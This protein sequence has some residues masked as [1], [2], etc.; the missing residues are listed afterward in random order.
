MSDHSISKATLG[1]LPEYLRLLKLIEKEHK[2]ISATVIAKY[3]GFGEVQVRKNLGAVSGKGKPKIVYVTSE[4]IERLEYCLGRNNLCQVVIVGAGKLGRALLDYQ[5]FSD[6]GLEIVAAFDSAV[7]DVM[8]SESGKPIYP[9]R[10]FEG[11]CYKC[12]IKIGV[13][14]VPKSAA[15]EIC[16][17]MVKNNIS[18][19]WNF[20]PEI[21]HVPDNVVVQ[22]E[23]LALSL[24]YLN[25]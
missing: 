3:L 4:L 21:L 23:N 17:L 24:A 15:Q 2:T 13:I 7:D 1:R 14:T 5:G 25:Q 11:F 16:D 9:M 6:Y 19:I 20:A 22:Q 18:A 12:D 10:E 8:F